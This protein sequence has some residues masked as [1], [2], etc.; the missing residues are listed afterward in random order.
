MNLHFFASGDGPFYFDSVLKSPLPYRLYDSA[1]D[2]GVSLINRYWYEMPFQKMVELLSGLGLGWFYIDKL[3]WLGGVFVLVASADYLMRQL[4]YRLIHRALGT[5]VYAANTYAL[6][7]FGGG[8]YG[9]FI[10]Y[11]LTPFLI[12]KTIRWVWEAGQQKNLINYAVVSLALTTGTLVAID[13]R[14]GALAVFIALMIACGLIYASK[15]GSRH[16]VTQAGIISAI[17]ILLQSYW[18]VPA[19]FSENALAGDSYTGSGILSFLSSADF[20]HALSLLHP[21]WPENLFGKV[22]FMQPE[23]LVIPILVYASLFAVTALKKPKNHRVIICFALTGLIGA[24]LSKGTNGPLGGIY[25]WLFENWPG[26]IL[27]RDPTKFY[28]LTALSYSVLIP[29]MFRWVVN[30]L[31]M[32]E[33]AGDR[34]HIVVCYL[35]FVP[36]FVFFIFWL[37]TLRPL[38]F[39]GLGGN[40]RLQ[41]LPESYTVLSEFLEEDQHFYRIL[42][43]PRTENMSF[44]SPL[45][46]A[47]SG[48]AFFKSASFSAILKQA[49]SDSFIGQLREKGIGYVVIAQDVEKK[50]FLEN[51]RLAPEM[52]ILLYEALVNSGLIP[53]KNLLPLVAFRVP[54]SKPLVSGQNGEPVN[55]HIINHGGLYF[56]A[57]F[58]GLI[59]V[60]YAYDPN[61]RLLVSGGA[62]VP[63]K[64]QAGFMDFRYGSAVT[65]PARLVYLPDR[66]ALAGAWISLVLVVG[67]IG[68][69]AASQQKKS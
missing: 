50:I 38:W 54:D 40:F 20:S 25:L 63:E 3:M 56:P 53:A 8:Q 34:K 57:V 69:L 16:L 22:Y 19:L 42:W 15:T 59:T 32:G 62:V 18:L 24:F 33:K 39:G 41:K 37:L 12:G 61:F 43:L 26:F 21:N 46:P 2:F 5:L 28:L 67:G 60:R 49:G 9:V 7:L 51:Y 1:H 52:K 10:A 4:G 31:D 45:H 35:S 30:K 29:E 36:V 68:Y 14:L 58:G 66:K 6:M 65:G 64:N 55:F 17:A 48:E 13:I 27:F 47:V 23:F 44:S 11:S